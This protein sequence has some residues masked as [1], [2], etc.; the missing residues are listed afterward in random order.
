[1]FPEPLHR[2]WK[3]NLS[4]TQPCR[5]LSQH[6]PQ[7]SLHHVA[8]AEKPHGSCKENAGWE[9][10][11]SRKQLPRRKD[12]SYALYSKG[13]LKPSAS[14]IPPL[15]TS[16]APPPS[17]PHRPVDFLQEK[18]QAYFRDA[19]IGT[20]NSHMSS[21]GEGL[22]GMWVLCLPQ[23]NPALCKYGSLFKG[24][25][26]FPIQVMLLLDSFP[27]PQSLVPPTEAA[28]YCEIETWR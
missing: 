25:L 8:G 5:E 28:Q 14:L 10:R 4:L 1:M 24:D 6:S 15:D 21:D 19:F 9:S 26:A 7:P 22:G 11:G 16:V 20:R 2:P 13:S 18:Q 27:E 23:E 3:G 17:P 12:N